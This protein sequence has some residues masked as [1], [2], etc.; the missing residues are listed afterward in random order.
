MRS[1]CAPW[2]KAPE[3][4]KASKPTSSVTRMTRNSPAGSDFVLMLALS[5]RSDKPYARFPNQAPHLLC[6]GSI[7]R[8]PVTPD[9]RPMS[10][11]FANDC[12]HHLALGQRSLLPVAKRTSAGSSIATVVANAYVCIRL[13]RSVHATPSWNDYTEGEEARP[14]RT[15]RPSRDV[16]LGDH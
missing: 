6:S 12:P 4:R 13:H 2:A 5:P 1:M 10:S 16:G 14:L 15:R 3:E 8:F 7:I 11:S 9:A